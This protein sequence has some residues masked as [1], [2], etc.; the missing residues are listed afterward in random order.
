[1]KIFYGI[2]NNSI[3]VTNICLDKLTQNNIII[4]PYGDHNRAAFFTDP[5]P[6]GPKKII[7]ENSHK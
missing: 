1:M 4:I 5:L 2:T 3:D 6:R 7:I